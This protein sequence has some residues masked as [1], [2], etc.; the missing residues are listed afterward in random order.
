MS[1]DGRPLTAEEL[2]ELS[3]WGPVGLDHTQWAALMKATRAVAARAFEAGQMAAN[4]QEY[5]RQQ[6][7]T[8]PEAQR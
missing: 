2:S 1:S 3:A 5:A 6:L 8:E 4:A 7:L